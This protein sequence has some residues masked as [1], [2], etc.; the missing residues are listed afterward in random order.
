M[1]DSWALLRM[2]KLPRI[3]LNLAKLYTTVFDHFFTFAVYLWY[4]YEKVLPLL[5]SVCIITLLLVL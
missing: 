1:I 3:K 5:C 4:K 2:V